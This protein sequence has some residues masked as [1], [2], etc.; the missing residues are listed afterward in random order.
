GLGVGI[1]SNFMSFGMI[2]IFFLALQM[3]IFVLA[4]LGIINAANGKMAPLPLVG[5][6]TI[7]K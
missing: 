2:H 4:V 3:G 1:F 7:I 5:G 6:I